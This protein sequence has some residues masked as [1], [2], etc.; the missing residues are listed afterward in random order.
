MYRL[1]ARALFIAI[2][3]LR[4]IGL[5]IVA[6]AA[7]LSQPA[8]AQDWGYDDPP[9][10]ELKAAPGSLKLPSLPSSPD[11]R[12]PKRRLE[13]EPGDSARDSSQSG[14]TPAAPQESYTPQN[15]DSLS[16][17]ARP[18]HHQDKLVSEWLSLLGLVAPI[19]EHGKLP[20]GPDYSNQLSGP[21]RQR[22]A[23]TLS[24]LLAGDQHDAAFRSISHF[25][26]ALSRVMHKSEDHRADY[27]QLFRALLS[28]RVESPDISEDERMMLHEALGPK[29]IAEV[30]PPPLTEDAINAYTDMA[31]FLYEQSHPG[32]T[33]DADDNR[34]IFA[35]IVRDKFKK[36]PTDKDREAMNDFALS[37]AKFR[38]LYTDGNQSEKALLAA[39]IASEQGTKGLNLRNAM[40]EEVLA[41]PVWKSFI[42]KANKT[43]SE[44]NAGLSKNAL[45]RRTTG[46]GTSSATGT[47]AKKSQADPAASTVKP[48]R[49]L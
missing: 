2:L 45:P 35:M 38:I 30:G 23:Q 3:K 49:P 21:Q 11:Q 13:S 29:R 39:R 15:D 47:A 37:W 7:A 26:P 1:N 40:L 25:W 31:C 20:A 22:F 36:A 27:R 43:V 17:P 6:M 9:L 5:L 12:T 48:K 16:E 24:K 32:K 10:E 14:E 46:G 28:M 18:A 44:S 41:S 19:P 4:P 34:E 8:S 42:I 33:V